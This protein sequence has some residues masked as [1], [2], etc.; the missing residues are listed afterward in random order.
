MSEFCPKSIIMT[1]ASGGIGRA[2]LETYAGENVALYLAANSGA[3]ALCREFARRQDAPSLAAARVF[4][5]DFAQPNVAA[6]LFDEIF[7]TLRRDQRRERPRI[8]AFVC[9]AGLDLMTPESKALDFESRLERAWRI[10]VAAATTLARAVG[11][12]MR[13]YRR[14][15]DAAQDYDPSVVL[16]SWDGVAHGMKGDSAQ[17]Y[18]ACKGAVAA[19]ARSLARSLAP[20]V[21]V[22]TI[23]PGWIMT[24]W[25]ENA[26]KE[27]IA[28]HAAESLLNRW[29]RPKEVAGAVRFLLSKDAAYVNGQ[30]LEVNGGAGRL[31]R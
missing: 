4:Q 3:D 7:Q 27:T 24:T 26:P 6:A 9:A 14:E 19:F 5:A 23:A 29:G 30:T 11:D 10:D 17:I 20:D 25:A 16:F 22:N 18:S 21:R 1:G 15:E 13:S 31:I 8:D 2:L 28:R 12:A